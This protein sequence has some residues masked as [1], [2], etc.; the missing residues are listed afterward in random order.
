MKGYTIIFLITVILY[1]LQH[2]DLIILLEK[3]THYI[4]WRIQL[5]EPVLHYIKGTPQLQDSTLC[6]RRRTVLFRLLMICNIISN[7]II[8]TFCYY[9]YKLL[10]DAG[11]LNF[12]HRFHK[13]NFNLVLLAKFHFSHLFNFYFIVTQWI[14][15]QL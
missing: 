8:P 4:Y 14:K 5:K 3:M 13:T 1:Y 10:Y 9:Q 2:N 7:R 15:Q 6:R 12:K 11:Y